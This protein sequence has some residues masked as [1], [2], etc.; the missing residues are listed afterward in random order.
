MGL[1]GPPPAFSAQKILGV[2]LS[3]MNDEGKR[4]GSKNEMSH[5]NVIQVV[6][7]TRL[8]GR[9]TF[10][11]RPYKKYDT[12]HHEVSSVIPIQTHQAH[13]VIDTGRMC[14]AIEYVY[15]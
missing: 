8:I 10:K 14:R 12:S 7:L 11:I 9:N 13:Y 1:G 15:R 4:I 6:E 3:F 5:A 2:I